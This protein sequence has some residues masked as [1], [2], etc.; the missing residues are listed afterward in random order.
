[1]ETIKVKPWGEGQGDF[2][3][4]NEEDFDAAK[5]EKY[6]AEEGAK[7]SEN[8][9]LTVPQLKEALTAKGIEIPEGAKKQDLVALLD[10]PTE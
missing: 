2:V 5:H 1:M 7:E 6:E 4:I 8:A 3:V 9:K 10:K